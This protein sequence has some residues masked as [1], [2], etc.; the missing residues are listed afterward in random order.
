[1]VEALL[2]QL[3]QKVARA[4]DVI[5]LLQLQVKSL[6]AENASLKTEHEKWQQELTTLIERLDNANAIAPEKATEEEFMTV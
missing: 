2:S 6:E 1:M 3:E 5:E 4:I